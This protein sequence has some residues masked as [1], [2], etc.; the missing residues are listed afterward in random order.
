MPSV[1]DIRAILLQWDRYPETS[2]AFFEKAYELAMAEGD[3]RTAA[4]TRKNEAGLLR[5]TGRM[6]ESGKL[7]HEALELYGKAQETTGESARFHIVDV[8]QELENLN[9]PKLFRPATLLFR[10]VAKRQGL[11]APTRSSPL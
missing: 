4:H 1:W 5:Q 9:T 11:K 3:F 2:V 8:N 10:K 6:E 7:Y